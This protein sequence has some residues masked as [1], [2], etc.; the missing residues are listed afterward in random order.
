MSIFS[1][2]SK[3]NPASLAFKRSMAQL[4]SNKNIKYVGEKVDGIEIIIGKG[5]CISIDGDQIIVFSSGDV[6]L[7]ANIAEMDASELLSKEGVIITAPDVEH[8]GKIRTIVVY[9][10]YFR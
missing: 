10:V 7:R 1:K 9:Y 6:L 3:K 4:I 2:F 8:G 5:G